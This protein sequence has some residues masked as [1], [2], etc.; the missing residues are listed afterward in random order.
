MPARS[1]EPLVYDDSAT[2]IPGT[3]LKRADLTELAPRLDA[4]RR[5]VL[6]DAELWQ[7]GG[8]I[9][10]VKQPLDAGFIN[11]PERLLD[12]YQRGRDASELGRI[13]ATARRL[14]DTVDRV[15]LLGIGGS[16]MGARA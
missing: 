13:L 1:I 3:G 8:K 2:L 16:Y 11:L 15:V 6:A 4:A 7:S 14:A 10:A 12:D 9:P 5:E